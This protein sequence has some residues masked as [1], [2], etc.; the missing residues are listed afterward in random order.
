MKEKVKQMLVNKAKTMPVLS[1]PSTQLL[2]ISVAELISSSDM[3]M[4][5]M[6]SIHDRCNVGAS[7]NMMDL[8]VEAEA[9]G[10]KIRVT[11]HE[12]PTVEA[13]ILDDIENADG[14][15]VPSVGAGRTALYIDGVRKAKEAITDMPVFC[16][17]IGP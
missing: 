10:A 13:G 9:F 3:Q 14:I 11:D 5:G 2:G 1:F 7:L 6:V 17:V 16:G 4:K 15:T 12:I 8:S